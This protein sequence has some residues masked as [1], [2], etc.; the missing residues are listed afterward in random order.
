MNTYILDNSF[1][2]WTLTLYDFDEAYNSGTAFIIE[3]HGE[4]DVNV[5]YDDYNYI[6]RPAVTLVSSI[7]AVSSGVGTKAN[8]YV[9]N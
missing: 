6:A 3:R 5:L 8:P 7:E 1:K 2:W 4:L 9:I